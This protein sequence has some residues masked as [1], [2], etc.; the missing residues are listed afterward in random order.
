M[1]LIPWRKE[2]SEGGQSELSPLAALRSEMDRLFDSF[3]REPLGALDWPFGGERGWS[4]ALDI[5]ESEE[6]V[7]VRAEVPGVDPADLQV[8]VC[9][10]QLILAG[11]KKESSEQKGEDFYHTETRYGTFRRS[12][13]LPEAVDPQKVDAEYSNGVLVI[14]LKKSPSTP[15]KRI[16]VKVKEP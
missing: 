4:P 7:T 10:G 12:I 13:P 8:S 3:F 15:P 5:A 9:Q 11:E 14:H 16:E 6:E 1:G 2:E